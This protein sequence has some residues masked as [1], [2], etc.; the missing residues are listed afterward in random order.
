MENASIQIKN[1]TTQDIADIIAIAYDSWA[2]TYSTILSQEQMTYMLNLWYDAV[3]LKNKM[4]SGEEFFYIARFNHKAIGY[5]SYSEMTEQ[6]K[7]KLNKLYILPSFLGQ[8]V[9]K[10]LLQHLVFLLQQ[11]NMNRI[12][13]NV[14]KYNS[15]AIAFYKKNG[16]HVLKEEVL[17]IGNGFIMDDYVLEKILP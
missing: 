9:G 4:L 13:L 10:K 16:F 12:V 5:M 6:Q 2:V 11:Q 17:Q 1:A 7:A 3:G 8:G 15:N 14:N